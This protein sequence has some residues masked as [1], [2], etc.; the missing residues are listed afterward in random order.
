M[1]GTV[2]GWIIRRMDCM[3]GWMDTDATDWM[4]GDFTSA[5]LTNITYLALVLG[6]YIGSAVIT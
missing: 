2:Y 1:G 4:D 6:N 5:Y 3:N